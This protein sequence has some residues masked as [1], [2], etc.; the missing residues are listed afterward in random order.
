MFFHVLEG[1]LYFWVIF[2]NLFNGKYIS[3]EVVALELYMGRFIWSIPASLSQWHVIRL[4][5]LR[6][7]VI[8]KRPSYI[9]ISSC[10]SEYDW[11]LTSIGILKLS[12][13]LSDVTACQQIAP[14]SFST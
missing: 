9:P 1:Y 5:P 7:D 13:L 14:F 4:T 12:L 10:W 11:R 6:R 8:S 2:N 3:D